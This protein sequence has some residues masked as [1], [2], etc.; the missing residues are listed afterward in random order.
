MSTNALVN[1]AVTWQY[2]KSKPG[3][4]RMITP[5]IAGAVSPLA[6]IFAC[7]ARQPGHLLFGSRMLPFLVIPSTYLM[8]E[9]NEFQK[10]FVNEICRPAHL[11]A[12][13]YGLAFGLLLR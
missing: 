12:M 7:F 3:P 9:V 5:K 13:C 10:G 1:F 4:I 2:E 8:Y 11:A 6:L